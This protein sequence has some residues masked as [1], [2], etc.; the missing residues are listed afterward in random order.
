MDIWF[1]LNLLLGI[2]A[3]NVRNTTDAKYYQE[4]PE[5][6]RTARPGEAKCR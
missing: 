5:E 1:L 2:F 3:A 4:N 6:K